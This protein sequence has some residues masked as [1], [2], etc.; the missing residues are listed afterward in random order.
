MRHWSDPDLIR[1]ACL[2]DRT[3]SD[4]LGKPYVAPTSVDV[5]DFGDD[6]RFHFYVNGVRVKIHSRKYLTGLTRG[7]F[8]FFGHDPATGKYRHSIPGFKLCQQF[9]KTHCLV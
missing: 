9:F 4:W 8:A 1:L 5:F 2:L 3:E 7:N 6:V